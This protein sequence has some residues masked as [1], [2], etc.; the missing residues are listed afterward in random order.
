MEGQLS[1]P[2]MEECDIPAALG[3]GRMPFQGSGSVSYLA[4]YRNC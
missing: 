3:E 4:W 2:I 1:Q